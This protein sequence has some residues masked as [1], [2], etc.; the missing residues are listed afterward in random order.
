MN[1]RQGGALLS[2]RSGTGS[3]QGGVMGGGNGRNRA[4]Q[5]QADMGMGVLR[6][7]L[8]AFR[9]DFFARYGRD[10]GQLK[11]Q[12]E[13]MKENQLRLERQMK[14][15]RMERNTCTVQGQ[16]F[17]V[18]DA[19]EGELLQ[20]DE[21]EDITPRRPTTE[22]GLSKSVK[23]LLKQ[24]LHE[25]EAASVKGNDVMTPMAQQVDDMAEYSF[26]DL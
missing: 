4:L 5:L 14:V 21:A 7:E 11:Q 10:I 12:M 18:S 19:H 25:R 16:T 15:M 1:G 26:S 22:L 8:K 3:M 23:N 17:E 24:N 6:N 2:A 13:T 20:D 9:Q